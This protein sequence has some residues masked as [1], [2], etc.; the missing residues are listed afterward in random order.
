MIICHSSTKT[1]FICRASTESCPHGVRDSPDLLVTVFHNR[2][3]SVDGAG[4]LGLDEGDL[5]FSVIS[6]PNSEMGH[7]NFSNRKLGGDHKKA[8]NH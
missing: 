2:P 8:G 7:A 5:P 4:L 6:S 3:V 1:M